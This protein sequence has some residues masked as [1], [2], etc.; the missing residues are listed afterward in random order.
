MYLSEFSLSPFIQQLTME[1]SHV[2]QDIVR[3]DLCDTPVPSQYCDFCHIYLCKACA[4]EHLLDASKQHY[5]VP[6]K[7]RRARSTVNYP[8]CKKHSSMQCELYCEQCEVSIC[9]HCV[10][11]DNHESHNVKDYS[12][13][14]I[15]KKNVQEDLMEFENNLYPKYIMMCKSIMG[16]K[17][18]QCENSK[19]ITTALIEQGEIWHKEIDTV[20]NNLK[21]KLEEM[22][23]E[24]LAVI[25][26]KEDEITFTISKIEQNIADLRNLL[27]SNDESLFF[28]YKSE[29]AKFRRI[30]PKLKICLPNFT[31]QN[32]K[33]E[34]LIKQF[35]SLSALLIT[36]EDHENRTETFENGSYSLKPLLDRPQI[37]TTIQTGYG[38]FIKGLRRVVV[39]NNGEEIWTCGDNSSIMSLYNLK[40][41]LLKTIKT[42]SGNMP[43]DITVTKY[44]D[45][46][47]TDYI[48]R[49]VDIVKNTEIQE[50]IKLHDWR[51]CS[52]CST[53]ADDLLVLLKND[54]LEQTKVVRYSGFTEIQ[55][56]Q[57]NNND[58]LYSSSDIKYITENRNLDICV[59][60]STAN[61]VVIVD[62][63]G[64]FR[65][66]YPDFLST[67]RR[68]EPIGITTDSQ[69]RIITTDWNNVTKYGI[70]ILNQDGK[71]L[72]CI[73][74]PYFHCPTGVCVDP[75]DN[76]LMAEY[77]TGKVKKI[78]YCL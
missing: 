59:T 53:S 75:K 4:E 63:A 6:F 32:I 54:Y 34:E 51:P 40:G 37:I 1:L 70:Y 33:I 23:S 30:P 11:S 5:V 72:R 42:R 21:S 38:G 26:K 44:G 19:K 15:R 78:K 20:I 25:K 62:H 2:A 55:S 68:V 67:T 64:Q 12:S 14:I 69:G 57:F 27:D 46:V 18:E 9:D 41:E 58:T 52:V 3:C 31:P 71:F 17:T 61:A 77:Y 13:I 22:D 65:L 47:Y 7:D 45:L 35:G 56:I 73:G 36:T 50:V 8:L 76:L 29:N 49:T 48:G 24:N 10:S 16:M 43:W 39:C 66:N 60:D 74:L 28:K